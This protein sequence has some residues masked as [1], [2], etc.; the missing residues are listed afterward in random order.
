MNMI[1]NLTCNVIVTS[2]SQPSLNIIVVQGDVENMKDVVLV[3]SAVYRALFGKKTAKQSNYWK[4]QFVKISYKNRSIHRRIQISS[5]KGLDATKVGLTY[6][7]I[8]ELTGYNVIEN[9]SDRPIGESVTLSKGSLI[10]YWVMHPN[11]AAQVSF[12]LGIFSIALGIVGIIISIVIS[13]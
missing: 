11:P 1:S 5:A 6:N 12:V 10:K 9:T 7:S 13:C 8:G 2:L 3:N 4:P